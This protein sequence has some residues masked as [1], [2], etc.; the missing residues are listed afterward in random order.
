MGRRGPKPKFEL[1]ELVEAAI[2]L[3]DLGG[4]E[5][6]TMTNVAKRLGCSVSG[7]YRYT[8]DRN[9]VYFAVQIHALKGF[10][11]FLEMS[12]ERLNSAFEDIDLD[13]NIS[14]LIRILV[15]FDSYVEHAKRFRAEHRVLDA[16]LSFP[17]TVFEEERG[18]QLKIQIDE[19]LDSCAKSIVQASSMGTL[20][21]GDPNQRTYLVWAS[22]HGLEHFRKR[23]IFL[24]K[25][26]QV[27]SLIEA[28]YRHLMVSFGADV[29]DIEEALR[30][31][32]R[33]QAFT[34]NVP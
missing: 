1:Q 34:V 23:D 32:L 8:R 10:S 11:Q 7:L 2:E 30:S 25:E 13:P 16:F 27:D 5:A 22:L 14:A 18:L 21:P 31:P 33:R 17:E 28:N 4:L 20:S 9:E 24:P 6:L 15:H 26:L 19:I 3:I 12:T 29:G